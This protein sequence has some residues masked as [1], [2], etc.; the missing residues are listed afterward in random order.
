MFDEFDHMYNI[1]CYIP[2]KNSYPCG[3]EH[4]YRQKESRMYSTQNKNISYFWNWRGFFPG[5]S[6]NKRRICAI[7]G[8]IFQ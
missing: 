5:I 2:Y 8:N 7:T 4:Y 3:I 6:S 1:V